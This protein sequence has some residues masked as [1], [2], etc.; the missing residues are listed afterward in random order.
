M[1]QTDGA[2]YRR[3]PPAGRS[4]R[5]QK[6]N[7]VVLA[8][9]RGRLRVYLREREQSDAVCDEPAGETDVTTAAPGVEGSTVMRWFLVVSVDRRDP[10]GQPRPAPRA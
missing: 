6:L 3:P 1:R 8:A 10:G 9:V 7:L 5:G 2:N 4:P